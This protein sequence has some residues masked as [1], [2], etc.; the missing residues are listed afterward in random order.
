MDSTQTNLFGKSNFLGE[1]RPGAL[2]MSKQASCYIEAVS[3]SVEAVSSNEIIRMT[4]RSEG[5]SFKLVIN[6]RKG[7]GRVIC[8]HPTLKTWQRMLIECQEDT[9]RPLRQHCKTK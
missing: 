1:K 3:S 6:T 8:V 2:P 4:E 9:Y 7:A 5:A